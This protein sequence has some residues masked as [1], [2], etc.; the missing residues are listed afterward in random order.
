VPTTTFDTTGL[1]ALP[2]LGSV[3]G[4]RAIIFRGDGGRE[5]LANA[6]RARG[7]TVDYVA[8]YRR[9]KPGSGTGLAEAFAANRV[10]A[11]TITSAEGLDNLWALADEAARA[12]WRRV[13]TLVPH[14]RIAARAH[15][16][17]LAVIET[18]GADAGLVAGLLE[19]AATQPP[20]AG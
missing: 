8:C 3:R 10:Q 12:A 11:A 2:E 18:A 6:L 14:P 15:A 7:A 19:W 16:L 20:R 5:D 9:A 17:G 4:R 13:P 1:L